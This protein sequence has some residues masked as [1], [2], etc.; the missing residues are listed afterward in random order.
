MRRLAKHSLPFYRH[1]LEIGAASERN[2]CAHLI[3]GD[4][5]EIQD[6]RELSSGATSALST[7]ST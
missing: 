2:L 6:A 1:G 3:D 7:C 5:V 4:G